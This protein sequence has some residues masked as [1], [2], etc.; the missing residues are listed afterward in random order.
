[1]GWGDMPRGM[2]TVESMTP[3]A[4]WALGNQFTAADIVFGGA[5][6]LFSDFKMMNLSP[7]VAAY[8]ERIKA[9]PIYKATHADF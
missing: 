8:V 2:A 1:M 4:G 9:R 3:E 7:K 6:A 5:L